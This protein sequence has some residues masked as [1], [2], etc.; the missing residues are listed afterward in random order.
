MGLCWVIYLHI[1]VADM[2]EWNTHFRSLTLDILVVCFFI[3]LMPSW[4]WL[5]LWM[6]QENGRKLVSSRF[7]QHT[8]IHESVKGR[9]GN[10]SLLTASTSFVAFDSLFRGASLFCVSPSFGIDFVVLPVFFCCVAASGSRLL[11]LAKFINNSRSSAFVVLPVSFCRITAYG[12]F[13]RWSERRRKTGEFKTRTTQ[14]DTSHFATSASVADFSSL[15][16]RALS[17]SSFAAACC[18]STC[19]W[20]ACLTKKAVEGETEAKPSLG[21]L[22]KVFVVP[23]VCFRSITEGLFCGW[24]KRMED[25]W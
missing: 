21:P 9:E 18:C 16:F 6:K 12:L 23:S 19:S 1:G 15:A 2:I 4:I 11:P 14:N 5:V 13:C 7:A 8:M 3:F 25:I 22:G 10:T 20:P 24:N 17:S